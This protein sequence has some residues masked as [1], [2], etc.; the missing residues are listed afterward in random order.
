MHKQCPT[1]LAIA[2][3]SQC[4]LKLVSFSTP[5]SC[6]HMQYVHYHLCNRQ[7]RA[8]KLLYQR[9]CSSWFFLSD[10]QWPDF[11]ANMVR[12][13]TSQRHA[14]S[15]FLSV[16]TKNCIIAVQRCAHTKLSLF[17]YGLAMVSTPEKASPEWS[18]RNHRC[19]HPPYVITKYGLQ[20]SYHY[21]L[22]VANHTYLWCTCFLCWYSLVATMDDLTCRM[23][24]LV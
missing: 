19:R 13:G 18:S 9:R 22:A 2:I 24:I 11:N 20:A 8:W 16:S 5:S 21:R 1:Y 3:P 17:V 7:H 6:I 4:S 14:T 23:N 10:R 12:E 15:Y